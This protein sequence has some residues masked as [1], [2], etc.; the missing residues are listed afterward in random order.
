[1]ESGGQFVTKTG[2]KRPPSWFA[3]SSATELPYSL[4]RKPT[5]E[6]GLGR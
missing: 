6:R 2:P 1:M 3:G 4:P 5:L